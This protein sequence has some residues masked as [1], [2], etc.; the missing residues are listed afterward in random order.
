M[1]IFTRRIGLLVLCLLVALPVAAQDQIP[2]SL[3]V[4]DSAQ[5]PDALAWTQTMAITAVSVSRDQGWR[6]EGT[7]TT[8]PE[9]KV[10]GWGNPNEPC[11]SDGCI[12]YTVWPVVRGVDGQWHTTGVVEMWASRGV[13]GGFGLPTWREDFPANWGYIGSGA[14]SQYRP[15]PGDQMGFF[16]TQGDERLKLVTTRRERTNIVMVTLPVND[17]GAW[18]FAA[19]PTPVPTPTPTP[20]PPGDDL[21]QIHQHLTRIDADLTALTE[22]IGGLEAKLSTIQ[23]QQQKDREDVLALVERLS[24][25]VDDQKPNATAGLIKNILLILSAIGAGVGASK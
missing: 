8:W 1:S 21:S 3:I 20:V 16:L 13:T 14:M 24:Q 19:G 18:T 25:T 2:P 10:P 17:L 4:N 7:F 6:F 11:P 23:A 12:Q 22:L 9:V 5:V 15:S